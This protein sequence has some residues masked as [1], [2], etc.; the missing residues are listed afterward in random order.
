MT[1]AAQQPQWERPRALDN[2]PIV[3]E[4]K[5]WELVSIPEN[6]ETRDEIINWI[7]SLPVRSR[8]HTP[9][10]CDIPELCTHIRKQR[11]E[12]ARAATLVTLEEISRACIGKTESEIKDILFFKRIEVESLRSTVGEQERP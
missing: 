8:P 1:P 12:A 3:S 4:D 10:P 7:W 9:A 11:K 6:E 5:L 2:E